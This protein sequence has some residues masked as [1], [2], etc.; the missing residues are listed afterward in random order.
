M[1]II[2]RLASNQG[3]NNNVLNQELAK[4]LADTNNKEGIAEVAAGLWY[5]DK[6]IQSDCIKVMY[7]VGYIKP[8]LISE[9]VLEFLNLLK[10]KNN[11]MVWG[12]MIALSN[13]SELKYE[14][15]YKN[16]DIVYSCLNSGSVITIDNALKVLAI[17][18]SKNP[19]YNKEIFPHLIEHL[20]NCRPKEIPQHAESILTAVND[21]NKKVFIQ[22]LK[23]RENLLTPAQLKRVRKIYRILGDD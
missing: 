5:K 1:S 4:D 17:I 14:E 11:R 22:A 10:S 8:E 20:K 18:S 19:E 6:T 13:I 7:E 16:I 21:F 3:R 15:I 2:N 9:Y 23:E 12:G